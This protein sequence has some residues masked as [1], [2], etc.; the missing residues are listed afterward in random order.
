MQG[1]VDLNYRKFIIAVI[2]QFLGSNLA[3]ST[4][5]GTGFGREISPTVG[6]LQ[7]PSLLV[8][9]M[10]VT[11]IVRTRTPRTIK[12]RLS[13]GEREVEA[14]ARRVPSHMNFD[15]FELGYKVSFHET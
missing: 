11:E 7:G 15:T 14:V 5:H 6:H 12:F 9:V 13:D 3:D 1:L 4:L 8:Q 2:H 10:E